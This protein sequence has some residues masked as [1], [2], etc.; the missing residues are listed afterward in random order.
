MPTHLGIDQLIKI[1]GIDADDKLRQD[2]NKEAE[3]KC[4]DTCESIAD[5]EVIPGKGQKTWIRHFS[6]CQNM[7]IEQVDKIPVMSIV[8]TAKTLFPMVGIH[9][10][11]PYKSYDGPQYHSGIDLTIKD[12]EK[13]AHK[14]FDLMTVDGRTEGLSY[15]DVDGLFYGNK[16]GFIINNLS[17]VQLLDQ[18]DC[19]NHVSGCNAQKIFEREL[20]RHLMSNDLFLF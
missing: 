6:E 19:V 14:L 7:C 9:I 1:L 16:E 18:Y 17:A 10:D 20:F 13:T 4:I 3:Q 2:F 15:N 5:E 8:K 12:T 11:V